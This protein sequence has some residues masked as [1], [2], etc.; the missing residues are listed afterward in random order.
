LAGGLI[1]YLLKNSD[2]PV[3]PANLPSVPPAVV[4]TPA[5]QPATPGPTPT[6][7][8]PTPS[9]V[10]P[11]PVPTPAPPPLQTAPTVV[12][13]PKELAAFQEE[14]KRRIE[15]A[16]D[17][18]F[19][20]EM[21]DTARQVVSNLSGLIKIS[22]IR[23]D[24]G[25]ELTS[26]NQAIVDRMLAKPEVKA[27]LTNPEAGF[28]ILGFADTSGSSPD[29]QKLSKSR[30]E[31][32]QKYLKD[33]GRTNHKTYAFGLGV[34]NKLNAAESRKNRAAEIWLAIPGEKP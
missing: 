1:Y 16:D 10:P 32:V 30:A 11:T 12:Q 7:V 5:P 9:P 2:P 21:K 20:Q 26:E 28:I 22:T 6:P 23:F 18:K 4:T 31:S 19:D 29:N 25:S 24:S 27:A 3:P 34:S 33:Q 17:D 13:D 8:S 14:V 15:E